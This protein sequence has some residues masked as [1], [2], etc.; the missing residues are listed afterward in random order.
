MVIIKTKLQVKIIKKSTEKEDTNYTVIQSFSRT[1]QN[2][3][4]FQAWLMPPGL[5]TPK[6]KTLMIWLQKFKTV[7]LNYTDVLHI[8]Q[9]IY[10]T[11]GLNSIKTGEGSH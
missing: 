8:L 1:L 2:A 10:F 6:L 4:F 5:L 9:I 11:A 7:D 3:H